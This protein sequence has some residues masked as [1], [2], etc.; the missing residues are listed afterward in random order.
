MLRLQLLAL[1][2]NAIGDILQNA[3]IN[4]EIFLQYSDS[5]TLILY[6]EE[7]KNLEARI[8]DST[9]NRK[10]IIGQNQ[11]TFDINNLSKYEYIQFE[12]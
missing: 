2:N 9:Y 7:K 3:G 11:I 1:K 12:A 6:K 8:G 4:W 5:H 10:D